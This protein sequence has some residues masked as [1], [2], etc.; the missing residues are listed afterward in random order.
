MIRRPPRSTLFPYTTLFRS[1]LLPVYLERRGPISPVDNLEFALTREG[2]ISPWVRLRK[3][4]AD[5]EDRLEKMPKFRVLNQV[6][7]IKPGAS[8]MA[9]VTD[10]N[11]GE[12]PALVVQRYGHGKS[13]ALLIEIG[14][15]SGRERG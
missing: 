15:A 11:G 9:S 5:E 14:R 13:A 7:R 8:V 4:E 12:L 6:D 10:E 3:T 1:E 2:L